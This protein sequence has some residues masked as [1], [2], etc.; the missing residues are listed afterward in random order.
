MH[1]SG[2]ASMRLAFFM[3]MPSLCVHST[4]KPSVSMTTPSPSEEDEQL[5][6]EEGMTANVAIEHDF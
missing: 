1:A 6:R 5:A 4:E 3:R 2:L